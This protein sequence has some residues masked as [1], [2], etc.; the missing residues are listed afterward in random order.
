LLLIS[1]LS[2]GL[3]GLLVNAGI[4]ALITALYVVITG[5]PSWMRLKGRKIGAL[6]I[7]AALIATFTGAGLAPRP[8]ETSVVSLVD[9]DSVEP[10]DSPQASSS[11]S[12]RPSATPS[13]SPTSK[14]TPKPTAPAKKPTVVT[15]KVSE[16]QIIDFTVS[17]VDDPNLAAGTTQVVTPGQAGKRTV[18]YTVTYTDGVETGRVVASDKVT[19][20][21]ITQVVAN[22]TYVA[23][24]AP[25]PFVAEPPAAG[26]GC[27][28]NYDP[29][30]PI[31]SDVDCPGGSGNGPSYASGQVSVI[32]TDIYDLDRDGDGIGCD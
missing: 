7:G 30:V 10:Q 9:S 27:D 24:P 14:P 1:L 23:P 21:A 17:T 4:V 20:P 15:K 16:T 18:V 6:L 26:G 31:A 3:P 22:G 28:P 29:C 12:A 13:P 2:A 5:R 8:S 19:T 32:G 25:V 11:P